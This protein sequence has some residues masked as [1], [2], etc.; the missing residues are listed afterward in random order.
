MRFP[1]DTGYD[2]PAPTVDIRLAVP[3]GSFVVGPVPAFVDTGADATILPYAHMRRLSV[4]MDNRKFLR[5]AWGERRVVDVYVLDVGIEEVRLPLVEIVADEQ[6]DEVILGRNVLNRL[7]VLL[8][9]P[10][11][12]IKILS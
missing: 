10:K 9:G 7:T 2:P 6:G 3:E 1:Y 5:S 4:P 8:D 12:E 11:Q